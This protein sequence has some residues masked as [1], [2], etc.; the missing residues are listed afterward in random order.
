MNRRTAIKRLCKMALLSFPLA[1]RLAHALSRR[2]GDVFEPQL[3]LLT[4]S[5]HVSHEDL[6]ALLDAAEGSLQEEDFNW[7][8]NLV[9]LDI[10]AN[11]EA[12]GKF[13][14]R[15]G[16]NTGNLIFPLLVL[17]P[18]DGADEVQLWSASWLRSRR[19]PA[20]AKCYPVSGSWWSVDGDWNPSVSKVKTHLFKSPNHTGGKFELSWLELLKLDEL[21][22]LH[23]D[24]H[25]EM[26]GAGKVH[27]AVVNC[28]P[29]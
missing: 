4:D 3:V 24:H 11:A 14:S 8:R 9:V 18:E 20:A 29:M 5:K 17:V 27:W 26:T 7:R 10:R 12:A 6:Q 16:G 25:R 15:H 13:I 21:Q 28:C 23:S 19:N 1:S 2:S 22:S